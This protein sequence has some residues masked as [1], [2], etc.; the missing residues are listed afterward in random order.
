MQPTVPPTAALP[1]IPS[2]SVQGVDPDDVS[3]VGLAN[4]VLK[5]RRLVATTGVVVALATAAIVLIMP[6]SYTSTASFMPQA[7]KTPSSASGIAAQF[8]LTV[9]G[10]DGSESPD[11]YVDLLKTR[12]ILDSVAT[13]KYAYS[14]D[15]GKVSGTLINLYASGGTAAIQQDKIRRRL[16]GEIGATASARTNVVTVTVTTDAAALSQQIAERLLDQVNIF[17]RRTRRSRASFEREFAGRELA[18]AS[19]ALRDAE[20]RYARFLQENRQAFAPRLHLDEERLARDVSMRQQV[21]TMLAQQYEQAKLDEVRDTPTITTIEPPNLPA[22]PAS[23]GLVFK[24]LFG[25]VTGLVL[26]VLLSFLR[27]YA[28]ARRLSPT[29][30]LVEFRALS[31]TAIQDLKHPLRALQRE[32]P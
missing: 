25:L 17:N 31:K 16:I 29:P 14:V 19:A 3:V 23:R 2:V 11:F 18:D 9:P 20:D 7:P 27:A 1:L 12:P 32:R 4:V 13:A 22:T 6:R 10:V 30:E 8:G 28:E 21:Y 24:T 15:T 26:G 5:N